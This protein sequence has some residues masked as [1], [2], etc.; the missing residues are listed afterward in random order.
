MAVGD[1]KYRIDGDPVNNRVDW[2]FTPVPGGLTARHVHVF[3]GD[4]SRYVVKGL[5]LGED[6][7]VTGWLVDTDWGDLDAQVR[8]YQSMQ[9]D[10]NSHTVSCHNQSTYSDMD[11]KR[12]TVLGTKARSI[13]GTLYISRRVQFLWER[14]VPA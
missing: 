2:R 4:D 9:Q 11:L 12:F 13:D 14:L 1:G 7:L 8:A 10:T 5:A 6:L 3:P